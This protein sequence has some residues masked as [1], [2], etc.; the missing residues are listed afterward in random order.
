MVSKTI[1]YKKSASNIV[2]D[3]SGKIVSVG[4]VPVSGAKTTTRIVTP[5]KEVIKSPSVKGGTEYYGGSVKEV[6]IATGKVVKTITGSGATAMARQEQ[7]RQSFIQA[8]QQVNIPKEGGY[9]IDPRT[10][11]GVSSAQDLTKQGYIRTAT[12]EDIRKGEVGKSGEIV[13]GRKGV[14][15]YEKEVARREAVVPRQEYL[16]PETGERFKEQ[17]FKEAL[18]LG[19][20]GLKKYKATTTPIRILIDPETG[21]PIE[22]IQK[23]Y[24]D[25]RLPLVAP[26]DRR[27]IEEKRKAIEKFKRGEFDIEPVPYDIKTLREKRG[28]FVDEAREKLNRTR[29]EFN[30]PPISDIEYQNYLRAIELDPISSFIRKI[31]EDPM[32]IVETIP[33]ALGASIVATGALGQISGKV[34][35]LDTATNILDIG[36]YYSGVNKRVRD[37][38]KSTGSF[39]KSMPDLPFTP[40][41]SSFATGFGL[42][43]LA[44]LPAQSEKELGI[45]LALIGGLGSKSKLIKGIT[46]GGLFGAGA[47]QIYSGETPEEKALGSLGILAVSPDILTTGRKI[48]YRLS[49][50][51]IKT[52]TDVTGIKYTDIDFGKTEFSITGATTGIAEYKP[53]MVRLEYIPKRDITYI[54]DIDPLRALSSDIAFRDKPKLPKLTVEQKKILGV[55]KEEGGI[56]SGSFAQEALIKDSRKFKDLDILARNAEDIA[57]KIQEKYGD[58][59]EVKKKRITDSPLGE[60]DIYK[61]YEKKTGKQLADIDPI[62]FAEEGF[63]KY[64]EPIEVKGKIGV[65]EDLVTL[66]HGTDVKSAKNIAEVG[67]KKGGYL[68]T[69]KDTAID[70]LGLQDIGTEFEDV[71]GAILKLDLTKEQFSKLKKI[72]EN[73][74]KLVDDTIIP[75]ERISLA[76]S[77]TDEIIKFYKGLNNEK[78]GSLDGLKLLPPEVRLTSKILQSTRPLYKIVNGKKVF[79]TPKKLKV[80][81]DIAQIMGKE[82]LAKSPSLLRGY[83][84]TKEQQRLA[85]LQGD[86]F[87]THGGMD[88]LPKKGDILVLGGK[89]VGS[90]EFFYYTPSRF[91]EGIAYARRS[92]LGIDIDTR[93][94]TIGDILAGEKITFFGKKKQVLIEKGKLGD[95]FVQPNLQTTEIEVARVLPKE[96]E[97]LKITKRFK[98]ILEGE[99][100]DIAFAER[101]GEGKPTPEMRSKLIKQLSDKV[102]DELTL[103]KDIKRLEITP[104]VAKQDLDID[105]KEP[106]QAKRLIKPQIVPRIRVKERKIDYYKPIREARIQRQIREVVT[107]RIIREPINIRQILP[108]VTIRQRITPRRITPR[109]TPRIIMPR[110]TVSDLKI[111]FKGKKRVRRLRQVDVYALQLRRRGKFRTI[112]TGLSRGEALAIGSDITLKDLARTFKIAKTGRTKEIFGLDEREFFPEERLF[113]QYQI[114]GGRQIQKPDIFIQ[115]TRALLQ[116]RQ[117]KAQIAEA[118]RRTKQLNSLMNI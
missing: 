37:V 64:F 8:Q 16:S 17:Q 113:R 45:Q 57:K 50:D 112:R 33:Y 68:T 49:G 115:R 28:L 67:F 97:P 21:Q 29:A 99:P 19:K 11:Q 100:I 109:V 116:T 101:M 93:P 9:F 1:T 107:P 80:V 13:F 79:D 61:V 103:R 114:K 89:E 106:R 71:S 110:L 54:E 77:Y 105:L 46:K 87:A 31:R 56:V 3:D 86:F 34:L 12:P 14:L 84:L 43:V 22:D 30:L 59:F 36:G 69:S 38:L 117:E 60:F 6:D 90:P 42:G 73:K 15:E 104:R 40:R 55:V 98:T 4:G 63:A 118:R 23:Y 65:K 102:S 92:R 66:Y 94:A 75:R 27:T 25:K 32:E 41:G 96:G 48:K 35:A 7:Q 39:V 83:G 111:K 5:P 20:G 74:F 70:Y 81:T 18:T 88:L 72:G 24:E 53:D 10:G 52:Q 108:R 76:E 85:F 82:E 44:E 58:L 95:E 78:V 62:N 47:Y 2:R 51:F 91:E 26:E